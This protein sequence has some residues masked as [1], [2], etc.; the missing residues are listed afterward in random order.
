MAKYRLTEKECFK[1]LRQLSREGKINASIKFNHMLRHRI[2]VLTTRYNWQID[3]ERSA[4]DRTQQTLLWKKAIFQKKRRLLGFAILYNG[5]QYE[6]RFHIITEGL[7]KW[8]NYYRRDYCD[9]CGRLGWKN[10]RTTCVSCDPVYSKCQVCG[11]PANTRHYSTYTFIEMCQYL[12]LDSWK[13]ICPHCLQQ[14]K[15]KFKLEM[16][17]LKYQNDDVWVR[18]HG[19]R[20]K[21]K[22][23]AMTINGHK[24]IF[25][26]AFKEKPNRKV[27]NQLLNKLDVGY[28]Q[29]TVE[30]KDLGIE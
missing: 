13:P 29:T 19:G 15:D 6:V 25:V 24:D 11:D 30:V 22:V 18:R 27:W 9:V 7:R 17:K 12:G 2:K 5:F 1:W 21:L 8:L 20:Y 28:V 16:D 3:E 4:L 26:Y 23:T 14:A 10:G